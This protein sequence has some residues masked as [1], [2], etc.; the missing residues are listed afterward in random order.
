MLANP[1]LPLMRLV[2]ARSFP[3]SG[4]RLWGPFGI[5]NPETCIRKKQCSG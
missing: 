1:L 3:D 2:M 4:L 5:D